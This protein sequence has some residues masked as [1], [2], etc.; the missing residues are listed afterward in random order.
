MCCTTTYFNTTHNHIYIKWILLVNTIDARNTQWSISPTVTFSATENKYFPVM[1]K[2]LGLEMFILFLF[3]LILPELM[4]LSSNV[5][6]YL[7]QIFNF[8]WFFQLCLMPLVVI[9]IMITPRSRI[10]PVTGK[11]FAFTCKV[12][13]YSAW[14][15]K[16]KVSV[17]IIL[18]G[19]KLQFISIWYEH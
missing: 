7:L 12:L 6:F 2:G 1:K 19:S 16:E 15:T 13:L 11:M 5:S 4:L 3:P 17:R 9:T 8:C 10:Q 14:I 18:I